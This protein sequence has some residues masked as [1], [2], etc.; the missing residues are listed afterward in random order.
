MLI[1]TDASKKGWGAVCKGV[2]TRG[3]WSKEEQLLHINVLELLVRISQINTLPNRQ[4][5]SNFLSIENGGGRINQTMIALSKEIWKLLLKKNITI[6]AEY[7][8][9]ALNKEADW[10]SWN[11]RDSSDWKL[12]PLIF[13]RIKSWFGHPQL[14]LFV[15]RLC[16]QL[17]NY[18]S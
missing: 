10:K 3:L 1:Q 5:N 6:S 16:R 2:Q 17:E 18:I 8:P 14:D 13:E 15:S 11:S 9:S 4:Q 7:L 12:C